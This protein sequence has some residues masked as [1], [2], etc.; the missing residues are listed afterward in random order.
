LIDRV[1]RGDEKVIVNAAKEEI[2]NA[3]EFD[4][5]RYRDAT[6]RSELN[7]YCGRGG[8]G[9]RERRT[10]VADRPKRVSG[11]GFRAG[12]CILR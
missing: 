4:E 6:Y 11:A 12:F 10:L 1:E 7:S 8:M 5:N 9:Y 2:Q 3:P